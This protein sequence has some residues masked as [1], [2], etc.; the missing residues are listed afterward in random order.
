M[1]IAVIGSRDFD[2]LCLLEEILSEYTEQI[3]CLVSGGC[4]GAD[5]LAED[6]D[7]KR[8][9]PVLIF[10]PNWKEYGRSAGVIRNREIIENCD[11]CIAFWDGKSKGTANGI[12]LCRKKNKP[13]KVYYS[14]SNEG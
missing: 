5:K 3:T 1:K 10:E 13:C 12:Q 7:R 4:R 2:N 14:Y 9:I 8:N 6:W 11:L